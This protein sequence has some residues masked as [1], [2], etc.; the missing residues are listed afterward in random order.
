MFDLIESFV[1]CEN[2][3]IDRMEADNGQDHGN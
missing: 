2:I 1:A 3:L